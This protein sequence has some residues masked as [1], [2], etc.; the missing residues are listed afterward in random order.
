M[1]FKTLF[2]LAFSA[3]TSLAF[4]DTVENKNGQVLEGMIQSE[5]DKEVILQTDGM[6]I[7]ILK[8]EIKNI[9]RGKMA[10]KPKPKE[11]PAP[12]S[13]AP[14]PFQGQK[15][16]KEEPIDLSKLE[17][18]II[19]FDER[20]WKLAV[21][22]VK[23]NRVV[24]YFVLEGQ[25]VQK[26]SEL[27]TA[28]LYIGLRTDP[29]YFVEYVHNEAMKKCPKTEW[30]VLKDEP[31]DILYEWS[32]KDCAGVPDQ[33]EIVRVFFGYDGLHVLHYAIKL[34]EIP[35]ARHQGWIEGLKNSQFVKP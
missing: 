15:P 23:N 14:V 22:D 24:A 25:S 35:E 5:N 17:R 19:V 34:G 7:S 8:S 33:S 16:S 2:F 29:K 20:T 26:W 9:T 12:V 6:D 30:K 11:P 21:Q 32:I 10:P 28:E 3:T 4:A 1:R 31:H 18:P 13:S 27:V